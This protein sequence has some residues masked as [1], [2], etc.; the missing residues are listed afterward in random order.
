MLRK[1]YKTLP[2]VL[3]GF[4]YLRV[5]MMTSREIC[6]LNSHGQKAGT[7]QSQNYA[8]NREIGRRDVKVLSKQQEMKAL[9]TQTRQLSSR[10]LVAHPPMT[11]PM[12]ATEEGADSCIFRGQKKLPKLV[13]GLPCLQRQCSSSGR[14]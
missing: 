13:G 10:W 12:E 8:Y 11:R 7:V 1:R 4:P 9:W 6:P 5:L 14:I 2:V 3:I